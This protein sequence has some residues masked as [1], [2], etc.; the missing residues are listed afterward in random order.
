QN[1]GIGSAPMTD[2]KSFSAH[3]S[4][5]HTA[6]SGALLPRLR[7]GLSQKPKK[8][9]APNQAAPNPKKRMAPN[10]ARRDRNR[11]QGHLDGGERREARGDGGREDGDA[12][13][14]KVD[15]PQLGAVGSEGR[16]RDR[17]L[18]QVDEVTVPVVDLGT[19]GLADGGSLGVGGERHPED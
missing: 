19:G 10:R 18:L 7:L 13:V 9:V 16:G 3:S 15:R 5:L 6:C 1:V 12:G 2:L 14:G 4:T 11:P 17:A 8:R